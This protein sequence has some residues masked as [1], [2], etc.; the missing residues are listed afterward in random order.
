M[1]LFL[2]PLLC[3]HFSPQQDKKKARKGAAAGA[4]S[5]SGSESETD[6]E[7]EYDMLDDQGKAEVRRQNR[8]YRWMSLQHIECA[9]IAVRVRSQCVA[10]A[11]MQ[12][13]ALPHEYDH[14]HMHICT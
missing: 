1:R 9:G 7:D 6:S 11:E 2:I 8:R 5:D 12:R 14:M 13:M 4:A 10:S 3:H